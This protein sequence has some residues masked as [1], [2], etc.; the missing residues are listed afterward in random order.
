[1]VVIEKFYEK[2]NIVTA[3]ES[4]GLTSAIFKAL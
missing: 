4:V 2:L 3:I 1:M